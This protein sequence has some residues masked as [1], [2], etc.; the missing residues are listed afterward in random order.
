MRDAAAGARSAPGR[1]RSLRASLDYSYDLCSPEARILWSRLSVFR[2]GATL[3]AIESVCD[4]GALAPADVGPALFELVDK[5]IVRFDGSHYQV[6][7]SIRQYGEELL[8][9]AGA[10]E[11]VAEEHLMY[12]ASVADD[13]N[14][15]WFGPK[16][17]VLS[18]G[19]LQEQANVRAALA[20]SMQHPSRHQIGMRMA[21]SL[22]VFWIGSGMPSEGRRWLSRL[23][24]V[25]TP[26]NPAR[27]TALWVHG[28]LSV[29]DGDIPGGRRT[30]ETCLR[31]AEGVDPAS[32]AHA[33]NALGMADLFDN[34][35][36][37]A[38]ERLCEG[39]RLERRLD[40]S[41]PYLVDALTN[42]GLAYC[43]RGELDRAVEVLE[44]SRALSD[45][46]EEQLLHSWTLV[47]L[48]LAHL[49][50]GRP[51]DALDLVRDGLLRKRA[52]GNQQGMSWAGDIFAWALLETGDAARAATL[53]GACEVRSADFG[54]L[55]HGFPGMLGWHTDYVARARRA[56]GETAFER[57]FAAGRALS[58]DAM[59]AFALDEQPIDEPLSGTGAE[60][61]LGALTRREREIATMVASGKTNREIAAEL[62]IAPRT[63]DTHVQ[64]IL[65]KLDFTSRQQVVALVA[66]LRA[67]SV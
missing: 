10:A 54:P 39:V 11:A 44:E 37:D 9:A 25:D 5:S 60:D 58:L 31:V 17:A 34:R 27:A 2:G 41:S 67:S 35:V 55:F 23:L 49:R 20:F 12:F 43:Y 8:R 15:D 46:H 40:A 66:E 45:A 18:A 38:I 47:F 16:Q 22:W 50:A 33:T 32:V 26:P 56:L 65:T 63:V 28:F 29:V 52:I 48:G 30:L 53:L 14:W 24:A 61:Q 3:N 1:H 4:G 36:E 42:L 6:L 59:L 64:N 62:V 57:A 21:S 51:E 13:L 19:L 7:E